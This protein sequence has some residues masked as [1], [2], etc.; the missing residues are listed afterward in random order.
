MDATSSNS[1]FVTE[2]TIFSGIVTKTWD[3]YIQDER[4]T[5][6]V[7]H[8]TLDGFRYVLVRSSYT[9]RSI[10]KAHPIRTQVDGEEVKGSEGVYMYN[11]KSYFSGQAP[12][13]DVITLSFNGPKI[14][15]QIVQTSDRFRYSCAVDGKPTKEIVRQIQK[16]D[17]TLNDFIITIPEIDITRSV[18]EDSKGIVWYVVRVPRSRFE[19]GQ[20]SKLT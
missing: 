19:N 11:I 20:A 3:F 5:V 17:S 15:I 4:H 9:L 14:T 1:G 6:A 8:S 16:N 13:P 12:P 18:G 2:A 7:R 10:D